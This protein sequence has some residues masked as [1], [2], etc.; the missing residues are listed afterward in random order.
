MKDTICTDHLGNEYP[1]LVAKCEAYN[2]NEASYRY[3]IKNNWSEED[4]LTK[5]ISRLIKPCTDHLGN[6]YPSLAAKCRAYDI[7]ER[8]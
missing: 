6:K 8:T 1:S 2:I 3:R 7:T 4:A 5:P